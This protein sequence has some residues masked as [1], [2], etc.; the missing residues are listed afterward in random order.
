MAKSTFW[1]DFKSFAI[2]GN[3]I[4]LAVGVIV[5]GAF[6]KIVTSLVNDILMPPLGMLLGG[7]DL[8]AL[9]VVLNAPKE[10]LL[11]AAAP[12]TINYGMFIQNVFDFLIVALCIFLVVRTL[13][14]LKLKDAPAPAAKPADVALLEEIRDL[15][16]AQ[17]KK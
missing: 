8:K 17:N 12:A 13:V 6:G 15:L 10:G 2:K 4:D 11:S 14:R 7:V 3:M 9:K 5:G 16:K 1:A